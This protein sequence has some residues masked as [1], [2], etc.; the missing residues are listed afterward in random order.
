MK[1]DELDANMR[2]Y[3]TSQD[4]CV[5]LNMYMVARID[6]RSF[7]RRDSDRLAIARAMILAVVWEAT[8]AVQVV[9]APA[10][11]VIRRL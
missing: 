9:A 1:F 8:V 5:L 6:G 2:D 3:E 10:V 11:A 4:R 7:T